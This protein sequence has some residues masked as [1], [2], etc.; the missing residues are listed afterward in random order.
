[1]TS[2][3]TQ[4]FSDMTGPMYDALQ[5]WQTG[6]DANTT[7]AAQA[8]ADARKLMQAN[9]NDEVVKPW[10]EAQKE[11]INA[12]RAAIDANLFTKQAV[13]LAIKTAIDLYIA[14]QMD[15][16]MRDI[17]RD[18]RDM[19]DRQMKMGE[20]LHARYISKFTPIE[21]ALAD[22]AKR[23]WEQNRYKPQYA[24][25]QGRAKLDA[26][27]AFGK[28]ASKLNKKF[29]RYCTG[30]NA[31]MI[32]QTHVDWARMEV[33][34]VNRAWRKEEAQMWDRDTV[35]WNRLKD[36]ILVGQK[37]PTQASQDIAAGIRTAIESNA[38]RGQAMQGW[39]G[40]LSKS[41]NGLFQF[42]YG[43]LEQQRAP[44]YAQLPGMNTGSLGGMGMETGAY[45]TPVPSGNAYGTPLGPLE[46]SPTGGS[47][48]YWDAVGTLDA[49]IG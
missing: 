5:N 22:F 7:G 17:A 35:Q 10:L 31:E 28:V 23:D 9:Y 45:T 34:M 6:V 30:A 36:A 29:T 19:A 39:Y 42:G 46:A 11:V 33:D 14:D 48:S 8:I 16:R 1:M 21:D 26:A 12:Q 13:M 2:Y 40:A 20:E 47:G 41:A 49:N 25:Q 18:Q 3:L 15:S 38:I 32:R 4:P 43:A 37:L 44:Q 27:R 24:M